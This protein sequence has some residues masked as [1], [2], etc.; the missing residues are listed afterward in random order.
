LRAAA[1]RL[2]RPAI[3][4]GAF[5]IFLQLPVVCSRR[6][7]VAW[8]KYVARE[9]YISAVKVKSHNCYPSNIL[10]E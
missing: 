7:V 10:L 8:P 4:G 6:L 5:E 1:A 3:V 2:V 9:R